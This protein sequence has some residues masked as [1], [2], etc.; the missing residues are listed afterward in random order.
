MTLR[1]MFEYC[2]VEYGREEFVL[3][4]DALCTL[5]F[6]GLNG[7][8]NMAGNCLSPEASFLHSNHQQAHLAASSSMDPDHEIKALLKLQLLFRFYIPWC[9]FILRNFVQPAL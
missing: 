4:C 5:A 3:L 2:V 6:L 7:V 8:R 9:Q 1:A